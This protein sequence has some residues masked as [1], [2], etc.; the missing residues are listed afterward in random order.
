MITGLFF[1]K[2]DNAALE[3]LSKQSDLQLRERMDYVSQE[4]MNE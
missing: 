2:M 1:F 4:L 3:H